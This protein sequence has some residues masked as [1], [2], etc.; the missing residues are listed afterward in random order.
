[1]SDIDLSLA[2]AGGSRS[3][4]RA[5]AKDAQDGDVSTLFESTGPRLTEMDVP[6]FAGRLASALGLP[7][8]MV[9]T[10]TDDRPEQKTM[11]NGVHQA[12]NL[13]GSLAASTP[14]ASGPVLLID[15]LVDSRWTFAVAA[16]LL[17]R[18]GSG[19]VYPVALALAQ[20]SAT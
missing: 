20:P 10:K 11:K 15:D 9:L 5:S 12:L 17:R 14:L 1:V 19:E 7:F 4:A 13:D 6:D 2:S 3:S 8:R 16:W 18:G